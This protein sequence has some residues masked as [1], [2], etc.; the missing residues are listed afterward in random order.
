[1]QLIDVESGH[2]VCFPTVPD[3]K[4]K[5]LQSITAAGHGIKVLVGIFSSIPVKPNS[6]AAHSDNLLPTI[7]AI[8][9]HT[10]MNTGG[11]ENHGRRISIHSGTEIPIT[12]GPA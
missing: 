11:N 3:L 6:H 12:S 7:I 1:M 2:S 4:N 9:L 8:V 5:Q 10:K